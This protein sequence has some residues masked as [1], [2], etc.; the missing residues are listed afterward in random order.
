MAYLLRYVLLTIVASRLRLYGNGIGNERSFLL[1]LADINFLSQNKCLSFAK[2]KDSARNTDALCNAIHTYNTNSGRSFHEISIETIIEPFKVIRLVALAG[3]SPRSP[4]SPHCHH[5]AG[6][7]L[8]S[9]GAH[10]S[11]SRARVPN[12]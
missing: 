8:V 9:Q 7:S 3:R 6:P 12:K 1:L 4:Q 5:H 11:V 10:A 2:L